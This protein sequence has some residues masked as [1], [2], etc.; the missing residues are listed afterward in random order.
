MIERAPG[1]PIR[2]LHVDDEPGFAAMT[3]QHLTREDD[4][5]TV[6]TA[7]SVT[8]ALDRIEP[9]GFDCVVSDYDMP[10]R[11]GV[12]FLEAVRE[13]AP[14]LPFILF[15]GKGSEEIASDAISRGVTDYLQKTRN[16]DQYT[17]LA[18]RIRN[19]VH[20]HRV[21]RRV[22]ESERRLRRVYE[23][24]TDGFF[25]VNTDWEYTYV[26]EEGARLVDR[27]REELLGTVVWE[28]FPDLAGSPF[29]EALRTAMD[30]QTTTSVEDYYPPHDRWYAVRVYPAED[31]ISIY[32]RDVSDQKQREHLLERYETLVETVGDP[33][34]ILDA[35]GRIEMANDAMY[36][37][38]DADDGSLEGVHAG[39][40]MA[41]GDFERATALIRDVLSDP[42]R[43]TAT[44][45]FVA[46]TTDGRERPAE[47]NLAPLTDEEGSFL[48]SVGVV[49]DIS[50]RMAYANELERQNARLQRFASVVSHDLLSPL[51]VAKGRVALERDL[52]DSDH[53]KDASNAIDRSISLV[54]DLLTLAREGEQA[55][56]LESVDVADTAAAC[57]DTLET[58]DATLDVSA[59]RLVRADPSRLR[60]LLA[61]LLQNAVDHGGETVSISV[62]TTTEGFYVAD[63]GPGIPPAEREQVFDAGYSTRV[64]GTGFGLNI[65]RE[66]ADA[67]GWMVEVTESEDGGVRFE[68]TGVTV[69]DEC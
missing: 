5:F 26:N 64:E 66:I 31:G 24:I 14:D 3:E 50:E 34:Y 27:D 33:M 56:D 68:I 9:A 63:D 16:S 36:D 32:F 19:A 58:G 59:S 69:P 18:N 62:G 49:R 22:E 57:W 8:E 21:E 30:A 17:V 10:E 38:V 15:T 61:N 1:D 53:L 67:H 13:H 65:V 37:T 12:E 28:A 48:G 43:D 20:A 54:E 45:E 39:A 23:R 29:E 51:N 55:R 6:E 25:G 46:R 4:R 52:R 2:I 41:E 60:Q 40:F 35:D 42:D 7:T 47:I 11:N 44:F